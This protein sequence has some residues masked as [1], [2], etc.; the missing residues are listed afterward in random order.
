MS[1]IDQQEVLNTVD[2]TN[3]ELATRFDFRAVQA[4]YKRK[5]Q[6]NQHDS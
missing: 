3:R 5:K 1:K 2:Y 4:R 6:T